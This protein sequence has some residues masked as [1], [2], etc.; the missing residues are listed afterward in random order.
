M[1]EVEIYELVAVVVSFVIGIIA[2]RAYYS[3]FKTT[4]RNVRNCIDAIDDAFADDTITKEEVQRIV[5]H[6]KRIIDMTF[7]RKF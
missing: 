7:K 2:A 3:K 6:C 5:E 4:L 1:M